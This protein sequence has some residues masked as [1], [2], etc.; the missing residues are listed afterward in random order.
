[1][2]GSEI[3]PGADIQ[4]DE[5]LTDYIRGNAATI[6]HPVGTCKMGPDGDTMAVVD[7]HLKVRG[8]EGLRIADA[9]IMPLING[10]NTNAPAIMI[11]EKAAD[12]IKKES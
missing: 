7:P 3:M 6:F 11:G 12:M 5:E 10:G 9:S 2:D 1:L 4:S 8:I